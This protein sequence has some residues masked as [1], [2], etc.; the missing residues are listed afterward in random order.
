MT[1]REVLLM[2][3]AE[4]TYRGQL[5]GYTDLHSLTLFM[6][7][8]NLNQGSW[9]LLAPFLER[10]VGNRQLRKVTIDVRIEF[11]TGMDAV[12]DWAALDRLNEVL[13]DE[14]F[15]ALEEVEFI[16]Q[17]KEELGWDPA[18]EAKA[19]LNRVEARYRGCRKETG[20]EIL[21]GT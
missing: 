3:R 4:D 1:F 11:E 20:N 16:L 12:V 18:E 7:S 17:L 5:E 21:E 10:G 2:L 9:Y 19:L 6:D 13:D 14:S 15:D 8:Y